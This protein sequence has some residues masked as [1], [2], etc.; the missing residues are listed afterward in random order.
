MSTLTSDLLTVYQGAEEYL[1]T[2]GRK[3]TLV[4]QARYERPCP[5]CRKPIQKN[6]PIINYEK[7]N[8]RWMWVC[9][10]CAP[11]NPYEPPS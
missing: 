3:V 11:E 6:A 7:V 10:N 9:L 5:K 2:L 1:S 4:W 8:Y